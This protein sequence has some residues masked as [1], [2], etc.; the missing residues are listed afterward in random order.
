MASP[1]G[2][3]KLSALDEDE[4]VDEARSFRN[5]PSE[6]MIWPERTE[7][8]VSRWLFL[9]VTPMLKLGSREHLEHTDLWSLDPKE[10]TAHNYPRFKIL[11]AD[12]H[13]RCK[14]SGSEFAL[15]RPVLALVKPQVLKAAALRVFNVGCSLSR[16][17]VLQQVLLV[18]E[19][20]PA[21]VE[22]EHAWMLAVGMM[23]CSF[24]EF[25]GYSHY[26]HLVNKASW[27]LREAIIGML[28]NHVA[29][30]NLG[31]KNSYSGGKITNLMSSDAD[32]V[33]FMTIQLNLLWIIPI[34][35]VVSLYL[36]ISLL[37]PSGLVGLVMTLVLGP[38]TRKFIGKLH[39]LQTDARK[40][41]DERVR[42]VLECM[43]GIRILKVRTPHT[44]ERSFRP[45]VDSVRHCPAPSVA[46]HG[47]GGKFR[48]QDRC[49]A[50]E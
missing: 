33:R 10:C 14:A 49:C 3:A 7:S 5:C 21:W 42:Y 39:K 11:L 18:V 27:D 37:G 40:Q 32:R 41:T 8:F 24:G 30:L 35:F 17:L 23:A 28:Y 9:W 15:W 44:C 20:A 12:E 36:V 48:G 50:G 47:L 34:Q 13:Q 4:P 19:G 26:M 29:D 22:P 31:A 43:S 2:Y 46:V 25:M 16:P 1:G 6:K 45:A 38:I